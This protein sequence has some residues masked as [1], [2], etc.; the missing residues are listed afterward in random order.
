MQNEKAENSDSYKGTTTKKN[1]LEKQLSD[2]EITNLYERDFRL[3][4]VKMNQDLGN[5][6][7]AKIENY[8]EH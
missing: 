3:M 8:K 7:E 5:T 4:I 6:L 1:P 2:L